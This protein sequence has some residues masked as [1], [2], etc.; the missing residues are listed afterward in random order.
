MG[1]FESELGSSGAS[2]DGMAQFYH[3]CIVTKYSTVEIVIMHNT[4]SLG[5][6]HYWD[7]EIHITGGGHQNVHGG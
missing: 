3:P 4:G 7:S 2:G 1:P 5:A 6:E